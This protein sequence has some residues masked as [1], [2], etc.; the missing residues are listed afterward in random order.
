MTMTKG[1]IFNIQRFSI[2]DGP[3]I[4]TTVFFKGCSLFCFWCH[5]PEGRRAKPEIQFFP[6]CCI[7]CNECVKVCKHDGH[8]IVNGVHV[9]RRERCTACGRCADGCFAGAL[10]STG[11]EVTVDDVMAEVRSDRSFYQTSGGGVTLSGGEPLLQPEFAREILARSKAEGI[12]TAIETAAN[13]RWRDLETL[14]PFTNLVMMD[15]K[16]MDAAKHRAVT[17]VSNE[18]IL[19]NARRLAE[20]GAHMQFRVP[21]IPTVNDTAP[22]IQA[23]AAFVCDLPSSGAQPSLE[24]LPFHRLAG[25]KFRSLGLDDR[26]APLTPLS[27]EQMAALAKAA[28]E[29]GIS[30]SRPALQ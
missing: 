8:A 26:S 15:I 23:I 30:A 28:Q 18:R 9:Y 12:H 2:H 10:Q 13:C 19:K 1:V 21:V 5:N 27:K 22:E 16:H 14:L 11:K 17:G 7:G 25:D 6:E 24:L 3:G 4:R 29:C 20:C